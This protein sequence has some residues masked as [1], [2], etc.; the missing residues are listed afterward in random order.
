MYRQS[1]VIREIIRKDE[2]ESDLFFEKKKKR[3]SARTVYGQACYMKNLLLP[4]PYLYLE[5]LYTGSPD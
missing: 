2:D 4:T 5:F 3:S 1:D